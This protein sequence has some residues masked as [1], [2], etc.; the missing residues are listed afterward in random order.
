VSYPNAD[1]KAA[2]A[3]GAALRRV[4]YSEPAVLEMLGEES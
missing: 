1:P 4:R 3:L 2:A